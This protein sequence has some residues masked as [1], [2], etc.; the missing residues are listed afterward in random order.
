MP[1]QCTFCTEVFKTKYDWQRHEK[2][3]HLPLESWVCALQGPRISK[4]GIGEQCCV[5]CG[6]PSPDDS[7]IETHHYSACQERD[8]QERTFHRKDHLVQHLR[9]VHGAEFLE[10]SMTPWMLTIPNVRSRCGFC[11]INMSTWP[12]RIDHLADHFKSG[13]TMA[14]W[15]GDWGFD[16]SI[17]PLVETAI[18]PDLVDWERNTLIPMKGSDP[19]WG[20][21]PNAYELLKVEIEFFIQRYFDKYGHVPDNDAMQLEACRI[22]FAAETTAALHTTP[23]DASHE[24]SWL[25]DLI[26]SSPELT[27]RARF[28]PIRTSRESRHFPLRINAKDHLFEQCPMESQLSSFVKRWDVAS[29]VLGDGQLHQ[30]ACRIVRQM[31]QETHTPSD[32]FANWI[33]KGIYSGTNWLSDFKQRA[34]LPILDAT[35]LLVEHYT[36]PMPALL[37]PQSSSPKASASALGTT[38]SSKQTHDF[39]TPLPTFPED[40]ITSPTSTT[41][42]DMYG[43]LRVLL[44]DDTNFYRIFDSDMRRWAASTL[45]R[46]NPNCHVPSD[47]EIQ[48]Q[49]RW[50][51]YD[52]D[53]PW[54]QTPADF[55]NWLWR[56]KRDVGITADVEVVDPKDLMMQPQCDTR[57]A[58]THRV[59]GHD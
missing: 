57:G 39:F 47:E 6:E 44:P 24:A 8:D 59:K 48:H 43:R 4:D 25:R 3:L 21:P 27:H 51:M 17:L 50:I 9:L 26:M 42:T 34:G 46:K 32:V 7:H 54:N 20:T 10:W 49:A 12:E 35:S 1:Y 5:F 55:P 15:Q 28:Q 11:G 41:Q 29:S 45:S 58:W 14:S 40:L 38:G 36:D 23:S 16:N 18:P 30:E 31:E 56:F 33:T 19:S 53:D 22:I 52:G 37:W 2:S 13:I